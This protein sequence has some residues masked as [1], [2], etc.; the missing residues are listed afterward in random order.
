MIEQGQQCIIGEKPT[1]LLYT[2]T[3]NR[4][5][6]SVHQNQN[7][8]ILQKVRILDWLSVCVRVLMENVGDLSSKY[9]VRY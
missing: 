4:H 5:M 2:Y 8:V 9:A 1:V 6:G 3:N 7:T